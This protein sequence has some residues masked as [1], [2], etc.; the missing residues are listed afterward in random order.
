M[1]SAL[2]MGEMLPE[3]AVGITVGIGFG[4]RF[5]LRGFAPTHQAE[6]KETGAEE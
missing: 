3:S 4:R 2:G 6:A 5:K 1:N